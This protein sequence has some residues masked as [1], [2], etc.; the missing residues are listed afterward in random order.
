MGFSVGPVCALGFSA[1]GHLVA[2]VGLRTSQATRPLEAQALVYP[3]TLVPE[4]WGNGKRMEDVQFWK[5]LFG[6]R[7]DNFTEWN[8][9]F[10]GENKETWRLKQQLAM[11]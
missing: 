3:C 2:S 11:C 10:L 5:S 8:L 4:V 6:S 1:G 9:V 7:G